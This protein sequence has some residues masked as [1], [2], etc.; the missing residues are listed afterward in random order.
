[1]LEN[2]NIYCIK[3]SINNLTYIGSTKQSLIARFEQHKRDMHKHLNIKLYKAMN[4]FKI[5][6]FYIELIEILPFTDI[7]QLRMREGMYIKILNPLLNKNIAGRTIAEY[8]KDN[9]DKLRIYRKYYY[10]G[11]REKHYD[12]LKLYRQNYYRNK[13][14]NL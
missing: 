2:G 8:Q 3:N 11:Y 4:E 5:E 14:K 13:I 1:M 7:K 6:N 10:R 9:L 12:H